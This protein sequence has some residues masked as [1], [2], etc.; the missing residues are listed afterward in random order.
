[1]NSYEYEERG[2]FNQMRKKMMVLFFRGQRPLIVIGRMQDMTTGKN[3]YLFFQIFRQQDNKGRH[4][5]RNRWLLGHV[6]IKS[7]YF[8]QK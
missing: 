7:G 8:P 3:H 4:V 5:N 6:L 1:M 2:T